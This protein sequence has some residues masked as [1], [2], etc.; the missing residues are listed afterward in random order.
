MSRQLMLSA[1]EEAELLQLWQRRAVLEKSGWDR[2]WIL[3]TKALM[4]TNP[5]ILGDLPDSKQDYVTDFFLN[6][7]MHGRYG[8]PDA[9]ES[10]LR[11]VMAL[12]TFFNNY[13]IDNLRRHE[14]RG[15]VVIDDEKVLDAVSFD[16]EKTMVSPCGCTRTTPED[17]FERSS[18][19]DAAMAF[20]GSLTD[21]EQL[22]L[23]AHTCNDG[24]EPLYKLA[25]RH[26]IASY[27]RKAGQL[28]I[29]RKKGELHNGYENTRIGGWLSNVLKIDLYKCAP[30]D[31]LQAFKELCRAAFATRPDLTPGGAQ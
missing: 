21:E 14:N 1:E 5:S 3:V 31:V 27:H 13:L 17:L 8:D 19:F 24:G 6:K 18:L 29:T 11:S 10:A 4:R 28:G 22:Y 15:T 30:T 7:V 12:A 20:F 16:A 25:E 9:P 23:A 2:L 26:K